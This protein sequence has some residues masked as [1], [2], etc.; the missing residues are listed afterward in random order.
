ML[1]YKQL[2]AIYWVARL[3]GFGPAAG[4]LHTSQS[5][6]SKRV[7]EIESL[8]DTALF[9]RSLRT[10]R[11]T[12]KGEELYALAGRL[13]AQRDAAVEQ[14]ARPE[15]VER[16]LRIG[17][18]E[19]SA[20]TWFP[21]LVG[22]V[23]AR[24][25]RVVI[26]PDVDASMTLRAKL[27]A[28]ELDVVIVPDHAEDSGLAKAA[29]GKVRNDWMC[30]PGLVSATKRFRPQDLLSHR[31]LTQGER[32]AAGQAYQ[33]WFRSFGIAPGNV[34][35]S[36][37]LIAIIGMTVSGLGISHLPRDCLQPLIAAGLLQPVKVAP[38]L[39]AIH[40]VALSSGM[41][42]GAFIDDVIRMARQ[43]CDFTRAFQVGGADGA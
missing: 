11:L 9:D 39:P 34:L 22:L 31:L 41:R 27:L 32:S 15:V 35:V 2:E 33:R 29:V 30:K 40:Y 21:R 36:N 26:E 6:I 8:F 37:N 38:A 19:L 10:A 13:L 5:A 12:D 43:C 16:R 3:G 18:T 14:F 25:P 17:L 28:D 20:M 7:Q 23:Q 42:R 24:Y 1:T 4:K